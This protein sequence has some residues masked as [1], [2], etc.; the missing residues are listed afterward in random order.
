MNKL[1]V[2]LENVINRVRKIRLIRWA[3]RCLLTCIVAILILCFVDYYFDFTIAQRYFITC[4][5][6]SGVLIYFG[7]DFYFSCNGNISNAEAAWLIEKSYPELKES[8]IS[9][10]ELQTAKNDEFSVKMMEAIFKKSESDL[11]TFK[12]KDTFPIK[13]SYVKYPAIVIM[14]FMIC[15]VIPSIELP[16]MVS[17]ILAPS[18]SDARPGSY[19]IELLSPV[20]NN[21]PEGQKIEFKVRIH[22]DNIKNPIVKI[23]NHRNRSIAMNYDTKNNYYHA[24]LDKAYG[25]FEYWIN[26]GRINTKK[27]IFMVIPRPRIE[28]FEIEYKYPKYTLIPQKNISSTIGDLRCVVGTKV[29]ITL[30]F[31]KKI[32]SAYINW[33]D[34]QIPLILKNNGKQGVFSKTLLQ[35]GQY[36]IV[37]NDFDGLTSIRK[38][39]FKIKVLPD[40]KPS[41]ELTEPVGV[42]YIKK[43][44]KV[45]IQWK[46][47]DDFG[48]SEQNLVLD[49]D[50]KAEVISLE[51]DL[52]SYVLDIEKLLN[53][54]KFLKLT[55]NVKDAIGNESNSKP[56]RLILSKGIDIS[57][58]GM[59][60][61]SLNKILNALMKTKKVIV[62]I[63]EVHGLAN[64]NKEV[65]GQN[66]VEE[67]KHFEYQLKDLRKNLDNNLKQIQQIINESSKLH[68][69]PHS[70]DSFRLINLFINQQ[71][72]QE[73]PA[74]I[75]YLNSKNEVASLDESVELIKDLVFKLKIKNNEFVGDVAIANAPHSDISALMEIGKSYHSSFTTNTSFAGLVFFGFKGINRFLSPQ[76]KTTKIPDKLFRLSELNFRNINEIGFG[77]NAIFSSTIEGY[78][79]IEKHL[80]INIHLISD[81]GSRLFINNKL[82]VNNAG[83]HG[84]REIISAIKLKPGVHKIL[85]EYFNFSAV[86]SIQLM[87]SGKGLPKSIIPIKNL[88]WLNKKDSSTPKILRNILNSELA[89]KLD[90]FRVIIDAKIKIQNRLKNDGVA[91]KEAI[92]DLEVENTKGKEAIT[93]KILDGIVKNGEKKNNNN[94]L[95][96]E[97]N[98]TIKEASEKNDIKTLKKAADILN[99]I[100]KA[101]SLERFKPKLDAFHKEQKLTKEFVSKNVNKLNPDKNLAIVM[102]KKME[103]KLLKD[104]LEKSVINNK[105]AKALSELKKS[106][107]YWQHAEKSLSLP[108]KNIMKKNMDVSEAQL[109][110]AK[111]SIDE[112]L[113]EWEANKDKLIDQI[114]S[115]RS[116]SKDKLAKVI[117]ALKIDPELDN[118]TK[119][120]L[121]EIKDDLVSNI[122]D[123]LLK[124]KGDIQDTKQNMILA[125][126]I[127]QIL[128]D[129]EN[130]VDLDDLKM[131]NEKFQNN[132]DEV[133]SPEEKNSLSKEIDDRLKE[134]FGKDILNKL[135]N[136]D[137][138]KGIKKEVDSLAKDSK[139]LEKVPHINKGKQLHKQTENIKDRLNEHLSPKQLQDKGEALV[140]DAIKKL[141]KI[142]KAIS[143][144]DNKQVQ[145]MIDAKNNF[146]D[147]LKN[148]DKLRNQLGKFSTP[149]QNKYDKEIKPT[150][151]S[152]A[153][154][155]KVTSTPENLDK[156]K[157]NL[158]ALKNNLKNSKK[159]FSKPN[160]F[161]QNKENPINDALRDKLAAHVNKLEKAMMNSHAAIEEIKNAQKK[162]EGNNLKVRKE[163]RNMPMGNLSDMNMKKVEDFKKKIPQLSNHK[164]AES[165]AALGQKLH[166]EDPQLRKKLNELAKE[167]Q[168]DNALDHLKNTRFKD[169]KKRNKAAAYQHANNIA[170]ELNK[171]KAL[172]D[173]FA[174][175]LKKLKLNV[176]K[177]DL[178]TAF[179]NLNNL[180]KQIASKPEQ[181]NPNLTTSD[182]INNAEKL[183]KEL[184]T[185]VGGDQKKNIAKALE[186]MQKGE[187]QKA[188][189][190]AK[191]IAQKKSK[192][193]EAANQFAKALQKKVNDL[194]KLVRAKELAKAGRLNEAANEIDKSEGNKQLSDEFQKAMATQQKAIQELQKEM[195]KQRGKKNAQKLSDALN[196]AI[197][198]Q[199]KNANKVVQAS[200]K[201]P[202][203]LK[204]AFAIAKEEF[205]K[206]MKALDK[207]INEIVKDNKNVNKGIESV[208][209]SLKA[210]DN[211]IA[212]TKKALKQMAADTQNLQKALQSIQKDDWKNAK[213]SIQKNNDNAPENKSM[214]DELDKLMKSIKSGQALAKQAS[215][216][217]KNAG[218]KSQLN[219]AAKSNKSL[220]QSQAHAKAA[221]KPGLPAM[222]KFQEATKSKKSLE[223]ALAKAMKNQQ[224]QIQALKNDLN[225][226]NAKQN[227]LK[228]AESYAKNKDYANAEKTMNQLAKGHQKAAKANELLDQ[229]A[230]SLA[231]PNGQN[232][233]APENSQS[234]P[235]N[236]NPN[237]SQET[238]SSPQ[239]NSMAKAF[240][241]M[242]KASK[243]LEDGKPDS[244]T[245]QA[246]EDAAKSLGQMK[247]KQEQA[248]MAGLPKSKNQQ[249]QSAES[250]SQKGKDPGSPM[251]SS[252]KSNEGKP[253]ENKQGD[254]PGSKKGSDSSKEGDGTGEKSKEGSYKE[255]RGNL[256]LA[257]LKHTWDGVNDKL[258]NK[259]NKGS[260]SSYSD[261]YKNANQKYLQ[262]LL[263]ESQKWKSE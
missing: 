28:T 204:N 90:D 258:K 123:Q 143:S 7:I 253:G 14:L 47:S 64:E 260:F 87:W 23:R 137:A 81:D 105:S 200:K 187:Y 194:K 254:K 2:V 119:N 218:A 96:A 11:D 94:K 95:Y 162:I 22:K 257:S 34:E 255:K 102:D 133:L 124:D 167:I 66:Y 17:R 1:N 245:T 20:I 89:L 221:G 259:V 139:Q 222:N 263:K 134:A 173:N 38:Y 138:L 192:E 40:H 106:D 6:Y 18:D 247:N 185:Q 261:Y 132:S 150:L 219:E 103:F 142:E 227:Q 177:D 91:F 211:N 231:K 50:G 178:E 122:E 16:L 60:R 135:A 197:A 237:Q 25:K 129:D 250:K 53:Y 236:N 30:N 174:R 58:S 63:S 116:N 39:I 72:T 209:Q 244:E 75:D 15:F 44:S 59:Y 43:N 118:Q 246:L 51:P 4:F 207:K 82:I 234:S 48:I 29:V 188:S 31:T 86:G 62:K 99:D 115:L 24:E 121:K 230:K 13:W 148:I 101:E 238:P 33:L 210:N 36:E 146:E 217:E 203:E 65:V 243:G 68:Y 159:D 232:A 170:N 130:K 154:H 9:A 196:K 153:K 184:A 97:L 168:K 151:D 41:I 240:D 205:D 77:H 214:N 100:K 179:K 186:D 144:N 67:N 32:K 45:L 180:K 220:A 156:I 126:K 57:K 171:N 191:E 198:G 117:E 202:E 120:T 80:N 169:L 249:G 113:K 109:S 241:Q 5:W 212:L 145:Q 52:N 49:I 149:I 27:K 155:K 262:K 84:P 147:D 190:Q 235:E 12:T 158:E 215:T 76:E 172:T 251:A 21:A 88:S 152:M 208:K 55:I 114:K 56:S 78:L 189:Q 69:Y 42:L 165:L 19:F 79:K 239:E 35:K 3:G 111:K 248:I 98:K 26:S 104:E 161:V 61:Q 228:Q 125:K 37:M 163:M 46:S 252:K 8:L 199:I 71:I 225:I 160:K 213:K 176:K 140:D 107:Q 93:K 193:V 128:N 83:N 74:I 216:A 201:N 141:E 85:I 70:E 127:D 10:T 112:S 256:A 223:G 206:T 54:R 183:L 164:L 195:A 136:Y 182:K 166:R 92:N 229:V 242:S 73:L 175:A 226:M 110:A 157:K 181:E 224:T 108:D 233:Q 131:L